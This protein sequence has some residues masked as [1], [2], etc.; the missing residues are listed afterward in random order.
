MTAAHTPA[1]WRV[2]QLQHVVGLGVWSGTPGGSNEYR[3][4]ALGLTNGASLEANACLIAAAPDL[5]EALEEIVK[6][7]PFQQSS[8]GIIARAAIA[9]AVTP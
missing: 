6:N 5:L 1:P 3:I 8:A 9:K 7:D 2:T 4:C